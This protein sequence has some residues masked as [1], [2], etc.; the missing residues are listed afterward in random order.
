MRMD[1]IDK[2]I[3]PPKS[4]EK[5][6]DLTRAPFA[7]IWS[8]PLAQNNGRVGQQQHGDDVYG[9]PVPAPVTFLGVQCKGRTAVITR[10]PR[11]P[12]LTQN[13]RKAEEFIGSNRGPLVGA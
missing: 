8:D 3:A 12:S 13:S 5:F 7:K 1:F 2:Q 10:K 4:W 11:R 9:T 6:E